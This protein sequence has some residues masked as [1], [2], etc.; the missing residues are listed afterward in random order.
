[1]CVKMKAQRQFKVEVLTKKEALE[2]CCMKVSEETLKSN[3]VINN[4]A[5]EMARECKG[6]PLALSVAGIA[7]VGLKSLEA[8]EHPINNLTGSSWTTSGEGLLDIDGMRSVH[9]RYC[10]GGS[11]IEKLKL[12]WLLENVDVYREFPST[13]MH[14]VI[15][16]MTLWIAHDQDKNKKKVIV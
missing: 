15:C 3:S 11:I 8:W 12:S 13:K 14:D 1:M 5:H 4:I 2:L 6:L 16:D 9:D 10:H 7:M